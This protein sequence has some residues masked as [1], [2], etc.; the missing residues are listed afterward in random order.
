MT[1]KEEQE[2]F[3]ALEIAREWVGKA[4]APETPEWAQ[5]FA[6]EEAAQWGMH[7]TRKI[8]DLKK[9]PTSRTITSK[10]ERR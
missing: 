2:L 10:G 9:H 1:E 3:S 5:I 4:I 7:F 6:L 8:E